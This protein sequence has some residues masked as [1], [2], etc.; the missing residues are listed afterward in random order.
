M[1]TPQ[2]V[3]GLPTFDHVLG[4]NDHWDSIL[5]SCLLKAE[6]M[7]EDSWLIVGYQY[8]TGMTHLSR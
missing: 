3:L 2:D 1:K 8:N 6:T 7:E 4:A 5:R